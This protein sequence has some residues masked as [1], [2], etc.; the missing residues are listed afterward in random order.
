M[1]HI[2]YHDSDDICMYTT[3][4]SNTD[5][6]YITDSILSTSISVKFLAINFNNSTLSILKKIVLTIF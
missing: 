4:S 6:I 3:F 1:F 2:R 5:T